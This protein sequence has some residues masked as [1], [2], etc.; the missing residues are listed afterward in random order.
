MNSNLINTGTQNSDT[1]HARTRMYTYQVYV[2]AYYP[3]SYIISGN[4]EYS[5]H[6]QRPNIRV[7]GKVKTETRMNTLLYSERSSESHTFFFFLPVS[8]Y[9][10]W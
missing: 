2:R 9:A 3:T 10:L 8:T 7:S 6:P 5:G 1:R 4:P